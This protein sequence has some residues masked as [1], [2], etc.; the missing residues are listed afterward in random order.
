MK[1]DDYDNMPWDRAGIA[2]WAG[3][4]IAC[5]GFWTLVG[6]AVWWWVS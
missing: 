1:P 5:L 4:M 2:L 6:V 3:I